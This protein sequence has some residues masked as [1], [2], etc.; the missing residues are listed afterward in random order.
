MTRPTRHILVQSEAETPTGWTFEVSRGSSSADTHRISLSW[1]DYEYWTHGVS[2]PSRLVEMLMLALEEL[3]P[4]AEIG[5]RVDAS[6]LRRIIGG[7]TLD[8]WLKE[9][10]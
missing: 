5:G 10:L 9:R 8:E 4:D 1:A 2:P 6:T 3:R 7:A